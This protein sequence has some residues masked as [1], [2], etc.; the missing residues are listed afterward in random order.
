[1]TDQMSPNPAVAGPEMTRAMRMLLKDLPPLA[2][3]LSRV[4]QFNVKDQAVTP[5]DGQTVADTSYLRSDLHQLFPGGFENTIKLTTRQQI[6]LPP[7]VTII[8]GRSGSGK[9]KLAMGHMTALNDQV[10]YA[11][12]GEPLDKYFVAQLAGNPAEAG[13]SLLPFEVDVA[14]MIGRFLFQDGSDVLIIDSLRHLVYAGGGATGKGGVNMTL[15]SNLSY[16]DVVVNL[17]GKSLIVVINPLTDDDAAYKSIVEAAA[18]SVSALIDV[19]SPTAIR[20]TSRYED[21]GFRSISLPDTKELLEQPQRLGA[22]SAR[23]VQ[24]SSIIN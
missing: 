14:A 1:M 6:E 15:F 17:R 21:R 7:G 8:L 11:R 19:Q 2:I 3:Q 22:N 24:L 9:T 5:A 16:L 10:I 13:I 18:G 23:K 4:Y 12:H 20:Y